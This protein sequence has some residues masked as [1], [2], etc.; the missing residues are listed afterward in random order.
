MPSNPRGPLQ[1]LCPQVLKE[2]CSAPRPFDFVFSSIRFLTAYYAAATATMDPNLMDLYSSVLLNLKMLLAAP[3]LSVSELQELQTPVKDLLSQL[4]N[5]GSPE[6]LHLLLE[7]L[8]EGLNSTLVRNGRSKDVLSAVILTKL[9]ASC[10]V[11]ESCH[12]VFWFLVPQIISAIIFVVQE[13]AKDVALVG[14]LAVP[15]LEAL[16]VILRC[17]EG[18]LSNPHHVGLVFGALQLVPLE[19]PSATDYF[20]TFQAVHEALFAVVQCHPQVM[21][22]ATP[23]FLNCFYRLVASVMREGRQ[24]PEGERGSEAES[25]VVLKCALLVERMYTHIASVAESFTVLSSFIV[26]QYVSELQKVTLRP[27]IKS[28]LTEGIYK[29]LDLCVEQDI[30]FLFSTLLPGV[31]EVFSE[32]Y[33][34]YTHHHKAQRQ[35]ED[36]YTA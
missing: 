27:E 36:K 33:R 23:S 20:S 30:K 16:T 24:R 21:L 28:H 11:S 29:I 31:R 14:V 6:Q 1:E 19:L 12:K 26:A 17:G 9:I 10:S 15:C 18:V 22:K 7:T 3:W 35:G 2:L 34:S 13:C 32:L 4:M 5:K 25:E 8:K